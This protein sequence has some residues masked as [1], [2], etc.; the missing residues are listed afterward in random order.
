MNNTITD[1]PGISVG[2]AT[3]REA[4]TGCTVVLAP[5][6]A[7]AGVDQRGGAPGPRETALLRPMH[8]GLKG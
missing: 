6:G 4:V 7:V 1:V 3:N 2:H 5:K 8:R